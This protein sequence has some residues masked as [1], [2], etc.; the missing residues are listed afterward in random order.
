MVTITAKSRYAVDALVELVRL[1]GTEGQPVPVSELARRRQIPSQF[2]EQLF[3]TLRRA[4][5]VDSRRGVKGGFVLGRDATQ[6]SILDVVVALDGQVGSEAD[7][8][9]GLWQEVAHSIREKLASIT[10]ADAVESEVEASAGPMY[11]I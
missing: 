4:G 6:I 8:A 9:T 10:I 3:G 2:L 1:N 11:Y 5:I 7:G